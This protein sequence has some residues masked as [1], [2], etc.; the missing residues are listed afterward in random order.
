MRKFLTVIKNIIAILL[1]MVGVR[2][3][4]VSFTNILSNDLYLVP[5]AIIYTILGIPSII[6]AI[7]LK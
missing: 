1:F 5:D 3:L 4:C 7:L 6:V 2:L